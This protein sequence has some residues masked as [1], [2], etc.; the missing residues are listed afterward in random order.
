MPSLE[1]W[2]GFFD[3]AAGQH[4]AVLARKAKMPSYTPKRAASVRTDSCAALRVFDPMHQRR[5]GA[6]DIIRR[7]TS[8]RNT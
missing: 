4:G 2:E 5:R 3:C 1:T 8:S 6:P 7:S